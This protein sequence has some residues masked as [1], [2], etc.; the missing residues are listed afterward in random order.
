MTVNS[1]GNQKLQQRFKWRHLIHVF[2]LCSIFFDANNRILIIHPGHERSFCLIF[3]I[4]AAVTDVHVFTKPFQVQK[5]GSEKS[6]K[7]NN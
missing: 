5:R 3:S 2:D 1:E 7:K 6:L 4:F